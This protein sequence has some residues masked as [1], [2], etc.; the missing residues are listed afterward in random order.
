VDKK[1]G[2]NPDQKADAAI[3]S[4][5][6]K[7]WFIVLVHYF[8]PLGI[9]YFYFFIFIFTEIHFFSFCRV[10]VPELLHLWFLFAK[11]SAVGV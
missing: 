6:L 7:L 8:L 1:I 9:F 5:I 2:R 10:I 4:S 11:R 3:C